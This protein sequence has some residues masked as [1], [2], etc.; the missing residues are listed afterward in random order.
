MAL[1]GGMLHAQESTGA[2]PTPSPGKSA[3]SA[4]HAA[5]PGAGVVPPVRDR[6]TAAVQKIA[7]R[8]FQVTG[9]ADHARLGITPAGIQS[10]ADAQFRALAAGSAGSVEL[11]FAQMQGVADKITERYRNAG[12]I[13]SNTF[14]PAQT[15]GSDQIVRIQV[16]EG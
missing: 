10:L 3:T 14:L 4:G 16:L 5:P 8:G 2:Q 7:V 9:V 11:S 6:D 12:F 13:V 15:V 1:T